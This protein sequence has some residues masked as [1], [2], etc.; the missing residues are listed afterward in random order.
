MKENGQAISLEEVQTSKG[1]SYE[2][3]HRP[4]L[5]WAKFTVFLEKQVHIRRKLG[6]SKG[7]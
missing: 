7:R 6:Q 4:Q 1:I 3:R 5:C 2:D